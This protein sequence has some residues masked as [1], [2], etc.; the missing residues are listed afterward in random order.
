MSSVANP[1]VASV[2]E[3][4]SPK[5]VDV[6]WVALGWFLGLLVLSYGPVL[7]RLVKQWNE[8]EDMGHG[9]F[10]PVIAAYIAWQSRDEFAGKQFRSNYWGLLLVIWAAFQMTLGTLGAE[11]FLA[12]TAFV[13]AVVGT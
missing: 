10:V 5:R 8:D 13:E 9:F 2:P 12:R 11:L 7:A 4:R 3:P 1:V 6:P